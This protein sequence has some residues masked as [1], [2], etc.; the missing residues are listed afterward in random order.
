MG[1]IIFLILCVIYIS[2]I[3]GMF[4]I[5]IIDVFKILFRIDLVLEYDLVIF[6]FC[7]LCIV[8]VG[9]VGLGFGVVGVVI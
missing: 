2:L 6:E 3:N 1:I 5:M 7:F 9:L 8:I 4:D